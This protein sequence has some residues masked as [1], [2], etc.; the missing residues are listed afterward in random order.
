VG[1]QPSVARDIIV[2]GISS[3][4]PARHA[5]RLRP[6]IDEHDYG[7]KMD[8]A[9]TFLGARDKVKITITFRGREMA[10]PEHGHKL[11]QRI[12]ADLLEIAS[13]ETPA[14]TE[15][16]MLTMVLMPKPPRG[17]GKVEIK[18]TTGEAAR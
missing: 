1:S 7:F 6:K 18:E 16:R 5:Q 17:G 9:R 12:I 8:H 11:I 13:V 14:R 2:V 3:G 4:G 10:H 15:G